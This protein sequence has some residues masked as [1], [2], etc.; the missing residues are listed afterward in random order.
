[1]ELAQSYFGGYVREAR[2][3]FDIKGDE[4]LRTVDPVRKVLDKYEIHL[5]LMEKD[6]ENAFGA[7]TE[8][9]R[10]MAQTQANLHQETG[11]LV[12]ALRQPHVRGRWGEITLK[13]VAE[14]AGMVDH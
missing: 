6:R 13:K 1:M 9:L 14:L 10:Q 12:K 2:K 4:I 11:N 5:G 8:R 3:E 7:I